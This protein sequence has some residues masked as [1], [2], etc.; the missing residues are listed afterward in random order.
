MNY[1]KMF[2]VKF[3]LGK[4]KS[5]VEL[6]MEISDITSEIAKDIEVSEIAETNIMFLS[7]LI[8][9]QEDLSTEHFKR[10]SET[11]SHALIPKSAKKTD[12]F[13]YRR[14]WDIALLNKDDHNSL[15]QYMG[16]SSEVCSAMIEDKVSSAMERAEMIA[17]Q[18]SIINAL[19]VNQTDGTI[20]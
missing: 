11:V 18:E 19:L 16:Y 6:K 12:E 20:H 4:R 9:N 17:M 13:L 1:L 7:Q 14:R 5:V 15:R 3:L 2:F 10:W 8:L